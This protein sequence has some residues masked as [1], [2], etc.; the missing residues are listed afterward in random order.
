MANPSIRP[1]PFL[2]SAAFVLP[3]GCWGQWNLGNYNVPRHYQSK[4]HGQGEKN[5]IQYFECFGC[6]G[7]CILKGWWNMMGILHVPL[8]AFN[9]SIACEYTSYPSL[10]SW[11][12]VFVV[13]VGPET[14]QELRMLSRSLLLLQV[15]WLLLAAW[16]GGGLWLK[17]LPSAMPFETPVTGMVQ[18]AL[19][20]SLAVCQSLTLNV[21]IRVSRF[22]RNNQLCH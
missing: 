9:P 2:V 12:F 17:S 11:F 1:L 8:N 3:F 6:W 16:V 21:M 10:H 22:V 5:T 14:L 20:L 18:V 15:F 13:D 7:G 4:I 19:W